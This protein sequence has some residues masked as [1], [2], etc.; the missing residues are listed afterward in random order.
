[1]MC[2]LWASIAQVSNASRFLQYSIIED[3]REKGCG[4]CDSMPGCEV[5][6][7]IAFKRVFS[8]QTR[9]VHICMPGLMRTPGA[10]RE[11]LRATPFYRRAMGKIWF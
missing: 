11:K 7:L 5:G 3:A 9:P 6:G 10:D 4:L 2:T 1:M 8:A